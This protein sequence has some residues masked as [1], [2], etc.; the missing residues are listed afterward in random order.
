MVLFP[1]EIQ[2]E[3]TNIM[4][5]DKLEKLDKATSLLER[6]DA[7]TAAVAKQERF[8]QMLQEPISQTAL[9]RDKVS[10]LCEPG[11]AV[12]KLME[13]KTALDNCVRDIPL[14]KIEMPAA[15]VA[16]IQINR[17]DLLEP[18]P[19][20]KAVAQQNRWDNL[21]GL[22]R[23]VTTFSRV[24]SAVGQ[25][26]A[27]LVN[28][29]LVIGLGKAA[30]KLEQAEPAILRFVND[31]AQ[32]PIVRFLEKLATIVPDKEQ[33]IRLYL[34]TMYDARWFPYTG[35]DRDVDPDFLADILD[36]IEGTRA[37]KSR[38][39]KIDKIVFAHYTKTRIEDMRKSWRT[40]GLPSWK[41]R[42]LN[43]AVRAFH[44]KEYASAVNT[45]VTVWEGIIQE[46]VN[47]NSYRISRRTRE[48]LEKLVGSNGYDE[49][50]TSFCKEF[51]FYNCK[52][53]EQVKEGVPGRHGI[54]HSWFD[55]YPSRKVALNAILFTD[56]LLKLA[57]LSPEGSV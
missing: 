16:Q 51:I 9:L 54:A 46:K 18:S 14:A 5:D 30:I 24:M 41:V 15:T 25:M 52:S 33:F 17:A 45:L 12:Q 19:A 22:N 7:L 31:F 56:F 40:V 49:I 50:V 29:P 38:M 37:S 3:G 11:S 57:P 4:I 55:R 1:Y 44:R 13:Q 21:T 39:Q 42:M 32:S 36:V 43:E 23:F 48:N 10:A 35:E 53:Q 6:S 20:L 26:S 27:D 34:H 8:A 47:D 28:S 2:R